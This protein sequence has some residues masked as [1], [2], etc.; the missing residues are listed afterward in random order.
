RAR[1]AHPGRA[2]G[3][4]ARDRLR[5]RRQ[6]RTEREDR[7]RFSRGLAPADRLSRRADDERQ[8][9]GRAV[10]RLS[11]L[12]GGQGH[13]RG[14]WLYLPGE[15]DLV[16]TANALAPVSRMRCSARRAS[17]EQCPAD[18]GPPQTRTVHASRV[19]PTCVYLSADL[20]Q[21]RDRCLQ[22]TA[23]LRFALR[24]ALDTAARHRALL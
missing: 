23:T 10:P 17:A 14:A 21:A 22:R 6:G 7:R 2:R 20:R 1:R 19:Y 3:S 9:R 8:A 15:G 12:A 16:I 24:R 4:R 5:D 18:P 11:A 13:I